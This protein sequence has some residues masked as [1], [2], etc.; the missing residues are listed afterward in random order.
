MILATSSKN[1]I[2]ECN[3][4]HWKR[5]GNT[6]DHSEKLIR[7]HLSMMHGRDWFD[8][9]GLVLVHFV[10]KGNTKVIGYEKNIDGTRSPKFEFPTRL[11]IGNPDNKKFQVKE[12]RQEILSNRQ[13][14]AW[15]GYE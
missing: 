8:D 4:C 2:C 3:L 11:Y 15:E 7:N 14:S 6:L 10:E 13:Q 9:G 5:K 1:L 12:S